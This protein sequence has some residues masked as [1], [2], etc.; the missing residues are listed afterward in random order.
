MIVAMRALALA[1]LLLSVAACKKHEAGAGGGSAAD[2]AERGRCYGNGTCNTGLVCLSD[3]CVRP[4]G[5]DCA[6]VAEKMSYLLLGNY[7]SPEDRATFLSTTKAECDS[8]MLTKEEG[9]CLLSAPHRNA[10]GRCP[11]VVGVGDCTKI[12]A[13]IGTIGGQDQY[14]VTA[15]DHVIARCKNETPAK[16]FEVCALAAKTVADLDK[17]SW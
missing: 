9:E 17:C 12:V 16:S 13:H 14:Q 8:A 7:A 3:L 2:G 5:A 4:P 1:L 15:V 10:L 6:K 11:K